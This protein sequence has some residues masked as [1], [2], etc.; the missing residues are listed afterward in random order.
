MAPKL[1]LGTM[2]FGTL[3]SEEHAYSILDSF[4]DKGFSHIDTAPIYPSPCRFDLYGVTESIIGRYFTSRSKLISQ[5]AIVS[6][7][8][9]CSS[10]KLPYSRSLQGPISF[11]ELLASY[12]SSLLRLSL[13]HLHAYFLHWPN[14]TVNNF[15]RVVT[16]LPHDHSPYSELKHSISSLIELCKSL[17][18]STAGISNETPLG[19]VCLLDVSRSLGYSGNLAIQNPYNIITPYIDIALSELCYCH[20]IGLYAHSPLAFGVLSRS[21]VSSQSSDSR[22]SLYPE[23]F[24]RYSLNTE[25]LLAELCKLAHSAEISLLELSIRYVLSNPCVSYIIIGPRTVEQL[26]VAASAFSG[27][28]LEGDLIDEI[29]GLYRR[30]AGFAF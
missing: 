15:G 20:N 7:K 5:T 21:S 24:S 1:V 30:V 3:V 14:R 26:D 17:N 27:G 22:A 23:Y 16:A 6:S 11:K 4:F 18:I 2:L 8:F 28:A 25:L 9:P 12:N 13:D 29:H 10:T 19:L